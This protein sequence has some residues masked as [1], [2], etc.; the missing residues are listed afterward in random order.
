MNI[1]TVLKKTT[2][3]LLI[4]LLALLVTGISYNISYWGRVFPGIIV[5]GID[6]GGQ[7]PNDATSLLTSSIKVPEKVILTYQDQTFEI[8]LESINFSHDYTKTTDAAYYLFR[9]GN[10]L[11]DFHNKL[12]ALFN[13]RIVGLRLNYDKV[14][15]EENLSVIAGQIAVE[16]VFPSIKYSEGNIMIDKG[17]PGTNTN[18]RKLKLLVGASLASAKQAEITIPIKVIDPRLTSEQVDYLKIRAEKYIGKK[19]VASFEDFNVIYKENDIFSLLSPENGYQQEAISAL[20]QNLTKQINHDPQNAVFIFQQ[21]K[22]QEF[23]P[24]KNGV[25]VKP[26]EFIDEINLALVTLEN[27][28]KNI[29][30]IEIPV[31]ETEPVITIEDVNSLGIKQLLAKGNS[32]FTGST[33]SR[34][35]NIELASSIFNGILVKPGEVFSF[36]NTLG[37]VSLFTGYKQAYIIKNGKTVLGDGGGVCQ[38]STTFFRAILEAGLPIVERRAH[39]YRVAY[40]EQNS[41][42]GFD[43]TVYAPTT[44]LKF[45]NDTPGHLLIQ[46]QF[47]RQSASLSFE[48]YGT[49]DGRVSKTTKAVVTDI[50]P[51]PEDLYVDDPTLPSGTIKQIDWKAWG[52][53]VVFKYLVERDEKIIYQKTF[54]SNYRPWQA[55]FLNGTGP[56]N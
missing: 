49:D 28:D 33:A 17:S 46:T 36:N 10:I 11:Y 48:I 7:K 56:T 6:I 39:S 22:V 52:A 25:Q 23:T 19:I 27:S 3:F 38:V 8:P 54:Y 16:P 47:N 41:P 4:S 29:V 51:P 53:K 44:D 37:D 18:L 32:R 50:I 13:K 5:A 35:H 14:L 15:L 43:A 20:T 55:I 42:P 45:K 2:F 24:A 21:N 9:S 34:I 30:Q 31:K 1:T 12:A 40:Y 26:E